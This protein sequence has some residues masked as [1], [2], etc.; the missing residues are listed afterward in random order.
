[1]HHKNA[2]TNLIVS[3]SE[4]SETMQWSWSLRGGRIL[5]DLIAE[6]CR[7]EVEEDDALRSKGERST[8][9]GAGASSPCCSRC[10]MSG[11]LGEETDNM[12]RG[13]EFVA[14]PMLMFPSVQV[15]PNGVSEVVGPAAFVTA[16]AEDALPVWS[17]IVSSPQPDPRSV[18][19]YPHPTGCASNCDDGA[20][21]PQAEEGPS[22]SSD[23]FALL[24]ATAPQPEPPALASP[25]PL[26][27]DVL[28]PLWCEDAP[29]ALDVAE[30]LGP[31]TV[32]KSSQAA[33]ELPRS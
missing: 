4:D 23:V 18:P 30:E 24:S 33:E 7:K 16:A 8:V 11:S 14:V 22:H 17:G 2:F 3:A 29:R 31:K 20:C 25:H 27:P 28:L 6:D 12:A 26:V 21:S 9:T 15:P 19:V 1:M 10:V 5:I 13:D 32:M